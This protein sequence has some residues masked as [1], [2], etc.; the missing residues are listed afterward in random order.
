MYTVY[1]YVSIYFI[2]FIK[3]CEQTIVKYIHTITSY[4]LF[5]SYQANKLL[6][7]LEKTSNVF[8]Y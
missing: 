3:I 6:D 8:G 1:T 2:P 5:I 7:K 4:R